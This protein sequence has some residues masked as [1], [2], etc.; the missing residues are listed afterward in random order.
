MASSVSCL[1]IL[2]ERHTQHRDGW[3]GDGGRGRERNTERREGE[4]QRGLKE[5][6][7]QPMPK[8]AHRT[9]GRKSTPRLPTPLHPRPHKREKKRE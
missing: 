4:T 2:A 3:G 1:I 9:R 8:T 6:Y 7:S 5:V